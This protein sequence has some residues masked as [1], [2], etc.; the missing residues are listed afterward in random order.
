MT[1]ADI[2]FQWFAAED[3]G[4]TEQP[5]EY[6]LRKA[7]EE[8]GRVPKSQDVTGALVLLI[9]VLVL[10]FFGSR[11]FSN[12]LEV[13]RF[14]FDRCVTADFSDGELAAAFFVSFVKMIFPVTLA[15]LA[16][17]I[18]SN[19]IQNKGFIFT[20][21][22]IQPKFSKLVPR[23][24]EYLKKTLFSAEGAFNVVKSILKVIV[25]FVVSYMLI[26]NDL[27]KLL[28]MMNV[29]L[30]SGVTHVAQMVIK[31]LV[32]AAVFFLVLAVPD[33]LVQRHQFME[34]MKMTKQEVKEEYKQLEGD[35]QVKGRLRQYMIRILQNDMPHQVAISD[36]VITNPTHFAVAV[37]YDRATMQAPA[38]SAKGADSMAQRIKQIAA[39]NDVPIIE[40]KPLARALYAEVEIGDI[41]PEAYL[42]AM[43]KILAHVYSMKGTA[44]TK[45]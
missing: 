39:E 31:L 15:A 23:F 21:K 26:K 9:P 12:C 4:R 30:W 7:R 2:D 14:Y 41:I 34:S 1:S 35:P 16:A 25:L 29:S 42:E 43:A 18:I 38:V 27:P 37:K 6:K 3:E 36:V 13:L 28:A 8:E 20:V 5:S 22:P 45:K 40:N 10:A 19:L 11:L 32:I 24:G 33:Y 44:F 17:G